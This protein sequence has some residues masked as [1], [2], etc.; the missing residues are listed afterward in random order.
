MYTTHLESIARIPLEGFTV[1]TYD[2]SFSVQTL[3][4]VFFIQVLLWTL[5]WV[6]YLC[7]FVQLLWA[8]TNQNNG[9]WN[10]IQLYSPFCH[11]DHCKMQL[12]SLITVFRN[13]KELLKSLVWGTNNKFVKYLQK[14]VSI[15]NLKPSIFKPQE[16]RNIMF[17]SFTTTFL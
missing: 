5:K 16:L 12:V 13:T 4:N 3:S 14:T 15:Q 17:E 9:I 7:A 2:T 8:S 11:C 10:Q 6:K 1:V